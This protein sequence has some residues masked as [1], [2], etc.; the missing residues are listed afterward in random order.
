MSDTFRQ[1][2]LT[3]YT[4]IRN[5][6]FKDY[7]LSAKAVGVACKLLSLPPDWDYSIKGLATLFS[8]GEAS[9]RSALSE[10]E[11]AGYLRREQ[12]R[13]DGKF[14]KCVYVITDML[15]CEKP[16]AENPHAVNPH[17]ENQAQY[18]TKELN[19][20][21]SNTKTKRF[22]PPTIEEVRAYI[23]EKKYNIDADRFVAYYSSNGWVVGRTKMTD[24]KAAVRYWVRRDKD[25]RDKRSN[26]DRNGIRTADGRS[27]G[28]NEIRGATLPPMDFGI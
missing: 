20:K 23:E 10:L 15:K 1:E 18:N 5:A 6:I 9:I 21:E 3:D 16:Y 13:D 19:T 7:T 25:E 24:W 11:E 26:R 14:G 28:E 4:V 8:D 22:T 27:K 2:K 12:V 17:A